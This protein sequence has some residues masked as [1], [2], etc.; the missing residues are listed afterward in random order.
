MLLYYNS[1][2]FVLHKVAIIRLHTPNL[3]NKPYNFFL[4]SAKDRFAL[5]DEPHMVTLDM[6]KVLFQVQG[7]VEGFE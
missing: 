2:A 6:V 3:L 7:S 4:G 1:I 5:R